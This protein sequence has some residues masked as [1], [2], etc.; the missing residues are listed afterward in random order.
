MKLLEA[1]LFKRRRRRSNMR[2]ICRLESTQPKANR[3]SELILKRII[4]THQRR[5]FKV[6]SAD[7]AKCNSQSTLLLKIFTMCL[8]V[9]SCTCRCWIDAGEIQ[10]ALQLDLVQNVHLLLRRQ[11]PVDPLPSKANH[12]STRCTKNIRKHLQ[13][14]VRNIVTSSQ[15]LWLQMLKRR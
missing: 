10:L 6:Q 2:G 9:S 12:R 15:R 7:S 8:H 11:R 14:H 13:A 3:L 1:T 5:V 4:N